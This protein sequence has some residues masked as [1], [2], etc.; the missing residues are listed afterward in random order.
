MFLRDEMV[1]ELKFN[2]A[3]EDWWY[4]QETSRYIRHYTAGNDITGG[5]Y[6]AR[7]A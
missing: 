5:A 1:K 2:M 4:T 6:A 3:D 7:G